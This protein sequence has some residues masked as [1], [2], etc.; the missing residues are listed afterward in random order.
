[1][2]KLIVTLV[3]LCGALGFVTCERNSLIENNG[4][5]PLLLLN[6]LNNS[7]APAPAPTV[8]Y[9]YSY[10]TAQ[11]GNLGDRAGADA[12]CQSIVPP[13]G[14]TMVQAF[15]STSSLDIRDLVPPANQG[16]PVVDGGGANIISSTWTLMWDGSIDTS[17]YLASVL[18]GGLEWWNGSTLTGTYSAANSCDGGAGPWTIGGSVFFGQ[19]GN[20]NAP[21][22]LPGDSFWINWS[23]FNCNLNAYLLCVAY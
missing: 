6:N 8:I 10:P 1:M 9:I 7:P 20:S 15:L 18:G 5:D 19:V 2:K 14:T 13:P 23:L 4:D 22:P 21:N 12:L 16:L 11:N 3:V 17:L